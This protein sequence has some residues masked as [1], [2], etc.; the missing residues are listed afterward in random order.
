MSLAVFAG[1][2]YVDRMDRTL[3]DYRLDLPQGVR[4]LIVG[5]ILLLM[6][7]GDFDEDDYER[8]ISLL[9]EAY[10]GIFS[11]PESWIAYVSDREVEAW[12]IALDTPPL[13]IEEVLDEQP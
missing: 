3:T 10:P 5:D 6:G 2:H 1:W 4:F 9:S 11:N 7:V 8:C 12:L 13:P